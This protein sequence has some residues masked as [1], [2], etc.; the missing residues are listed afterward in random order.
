LGLDRAFLIPRVHGWFV[1]PNYPLAAQ[2]W[3]ELKAF[4]PRALLARSPNEN[5]RR[6]EWKGGAVIEVKSADDPNSL[7]AVGLDWVFMVE[8]A[9]ISEEAWEMALRPRLSSPGRAGLAIF[10]GTPKGRNW[11][12]HLYLRGR[13]PQYEDWESWNFP[14]RCQLGPGGE[15]VDHPMGNPYV[16]REEIERARQEMP[17]RWVRQE[18]LAEFLTAGGARPSSVAG[19]GS[20]HER[21]KCAAWQ[22]GR[23]CDPD[24]PGAME[25][26]VRPRTFGDKEAIPAR[27]KALHVRAFGARR[28]RYREMRGRARG[29]GAPEVGLNSPPEKSH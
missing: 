18:F 15:L 8:A 28:E 4:T 19:R 23:R 1:A 16:R 24:T 25:G 12:Y 9:L 11:Y 17:D 10:N 7:V 26:R 13:D 14:T 22:G 21:G 5:G 29:A 2:L 20:F 3:R 27:R 6:L